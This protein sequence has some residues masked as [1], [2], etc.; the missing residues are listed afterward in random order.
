MLVKNCPSKNRAAQRPRNSR[1][2][3]HIESPSNPSAQP[4]HSTRASSFF[5][6]FLPATCY[7][8]TDDCEHV[9][10]LQPQRSASVITHPIC[11]WPGP[12]YNMYVLTCVRTH[13]SVPVSLSLSLFLCLSL[14]IYTLCSHSIHGY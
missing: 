8:Q 9:R 10:A 5:E 2:A 11:R 7:T 14:Y 12:I 13:V 1:T 3:L 4:P 6:Q